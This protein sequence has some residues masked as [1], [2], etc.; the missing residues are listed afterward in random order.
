MEAM[1]FEVKGHRYR[2]APLGAVTAFHAIRRLSPLLAAAGGSL[3]S[4]RADP[5]AA[6][7][8]IA[9]GLASL[10]DA[11][12]DY[13]LSACLGAVQRNQGGNV[14]APVKGGGGLMF[15][16]IDM[17]SMLQ[18]V[19]KVLAANFGDFFNAL[20]DFLPEGAAAAQDSSR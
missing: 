5:L 16:D 3:E 8:P 10:P 15:D 19:G 4:M 9:Q 18:I 20:R 12:A 1:E 11:D 6:L 17:G 7:L 13:V 14:W 2:A